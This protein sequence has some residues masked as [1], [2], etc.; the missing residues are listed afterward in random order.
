MTT[1]TASP[2]LADQKVSAEQIQQW[3]ETFHRDGYLFLEN[4]LTPDWCAQL[5]ADLDWALEHNPNGFNGIVP[6]I[7]L[8]NR[9]LNRINKRKRVG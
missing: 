4:V 5:R 9:V 8:A 3:V 7:S 6:K 2:Y 1:T